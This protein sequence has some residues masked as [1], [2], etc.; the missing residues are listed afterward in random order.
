MSAF[1][2]F[3]GNMLLFLVVLTTVIC[4]HELGHFLFARKAGILCHEFSF[5]MGPRLWSTK[6]GETIFSIRAFPIGGSVMMAGEEIESEVVKVGD[7]IRLG[8]DENQQVNRIVVRADNPKYQDFLEVQVEKIDLK[9]DTPEGL[10]INEFVVK[11]NAHYVFD[12]VSQQI[13]PLNRNFNSKTKGQRFM[14]TFGGPMM[15]L[16]L[17]FFV[18][19]LSAFAFGVAI[20]ESTVVGAV[21]ES[22]PASG[23]VEAGDKILAVNGVAVE[24]W[25]SDKASLK[26]VNSEL[27]RYQDYDTVV[28][29][30]ERDG[31]TLTLPAMIPHYILYSLGF[32]STIGSSDLVIGS[33]LYVKYAVEGETP[34][35][36]NALLAHDRIVSINGETMDDWDE[37]IA[38]SLSHVSGETLDVL[39]DR[40]DVGLVHV[41]YTPL[42]ANVLDAMGYDAFYARIGISCSTGFSFFGSIRQAAE[43]FGSAAI[44]IYKT[45][46]LLLTSKQVGLSDMSG[47]I[48]IYNATANAAS[49]GIQTL[50]G[51]IGLLS[52][53][54]GIVNLL[55]IPALDGGRI[56]FIAYEAVTKRKPN[57]KFQNVLNTIMF[58]LLMGLMVFITYQ[59]ILRLFK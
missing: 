5:G 34:A 51:W 20:T 14:T 44:T 25:Y 32:T 18:Y 35:A 58:F 15:N 42:A 56:A 7:K 48:G 36:E 4:I 39:V 19:L 26:T 49:Q 46:W 22:L 13:A 41:V 2:S 37:I 28:L 16:I 43:N 1:W 11:A 47:F 21:S 55:P 23:V 53:N 50:L 10:S 12:K 57:Q 52:V 24:A 31:Q 40:P 54:L 45:L 30:V 3:L 8:F 9:G 17:A 29:T 33:P 38:Y 6:R 59:D 27:S